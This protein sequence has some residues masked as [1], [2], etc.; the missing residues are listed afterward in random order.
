[1]QQS[2]EELALSNMIF[3]CCEHLRRVM[4]KN[5]I[6]IVDMEAL[7]DRG[8]AKDCLVALRKTQARHKFMLE[9]LTDLLTQVNAAFREEEANA[10]SMNENN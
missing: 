5:R 3:V 10:A 1:M 7:G 9:L 6:M 2:G 8:V 4:N